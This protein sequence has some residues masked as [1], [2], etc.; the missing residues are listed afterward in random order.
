MGGGKAQILPASSPSHRGNFRSKR[1]LLEETWSSQLDLLRPEASCKQKSKAGLL[2]KKG[3]LV[4]QSLGV[5]NKRQGRFPLSCPPGSVCPFPLPPQAACASSA[6]FQL[7]GHHQAEQAVGRLPAWTPTL[8]A[9]S[10]QQLPPKLLGGGSRRD[11]AGGRGLARA[12]S[13][14]L[15]K[16]T[17]RANW[18]ENIPSWRHC[19]SASLTQPAT[20]FLCVS[21]TG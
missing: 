3:L 17:G 15:F 13:E 19:S 18:S 4:S 10:R 12:M 14:I 8:V 2:F 6:C 7:Q 1:V 9:V 5:L 21:Y 16:T 11:A 20:S